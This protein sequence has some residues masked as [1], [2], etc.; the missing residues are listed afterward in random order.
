MAGKTKGRTIHFFDVDAHY[1]DASD[2]KLTHP[3]DVDALFAKLLSLKHEKGVQDSSIASFWA[4]EALAAVD[5]S[6]VDF[7][8]GR[9]MRVRRDALPGLLKGAQFMRIKLNDDEFIYETSHFVYFRK[10]KIIAIEYNQ[11]APHAKHFAEY[12]KIISRT[13]SLQIDDVKLPI[14]VDPDTVA[15][16]MRM[17][18]ITEYQASVFSTQAD[19]IRHAGSLATSLRAAAKTLDFDYVA[20]VKFARERPGKN[21][22]R[23]FGEEFKLEVVELWTETGSFLSS[24]KVWVEPPGGG[25]PQMID[26]KR[27]RFSTSL[28]IALTDERSVDTGDAYAKIVKYYEDSQIGETGR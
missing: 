7:V 23:G 12:L 3:A 1:Y 28:E 25:K 20:S 19:Q 8:A 2:R 21:R 4:L 15:R 9:F 11:Y 24:L 27:D 14:K 18:L 13:H 26:F 10:S 5:I 17:G 16:L 6:S 22:P